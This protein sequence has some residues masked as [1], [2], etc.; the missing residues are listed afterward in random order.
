MSH[1]DDDDLCLMALGESP[2]PLQE[3]HVAGC[4]RCR[5]RL[6]QLTAV[7]AS[8]RQVTDDDRAAAPPPEVWQNIAAEV[9][10]ATT[11][12][13]RSEGR[14]R[15]RSRHVRIWAVVAVAAAVGVVLGG[16]VVPVVSS[17]RSAGEQIVARAALAPIANSGFAGQ[18]VVSR[19]ASGS[20]LI[21]DVPGLPSVDG[22]YE[23]W[24]AT[25]DTS[26]MVAVGTL[27]PGREAVFILPPGL[28]P[29]GFP[30]VDVSL[31]HYDG[32]AGHS[33]E[34]VVRGELSATS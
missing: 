33:A 9:G 21:V 34:S 12:A 32:E 22:Y 11:L 26:T 23:V 20:T 1:C 28:D 10:I 16:V 7:V 30:V 5:S 8:A 25:P 19:G 27:T 18:A 31:E 3:A 6:D 2:G 24:M 14:A 15:G 13:S 17:W 4:G 29:T